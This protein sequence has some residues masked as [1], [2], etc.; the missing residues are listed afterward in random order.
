[1]EYYDDLDT[2]LTNYYNAVKDYKRVYRATRKLV[3]DQVS[4]PDFRTLCAL[5]FDTSCFRLEDARSVLIDH[6]PEVA[7]E[8]LPE[9]YDDVWTKE[10][11]L[12]GH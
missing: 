10:E 9:R 4:D 2:A 5:A 1:M 7:K 3:G 8:I 11:M 12:N 6:Y